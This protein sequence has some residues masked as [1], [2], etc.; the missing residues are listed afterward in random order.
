MVLIFAIMGCM[1]AKAPQIATQSTPV[2]TV[3]TLASPEDDAHLA[4]PDAVLTALETGFSSSGL[5]LEKV[6]TDKRFTEIGTQQLAGFK[7]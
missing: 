2:S 1:S 4:T 7:N 3:I 6:E 5:S